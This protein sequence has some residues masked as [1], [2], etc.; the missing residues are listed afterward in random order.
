[1]NL[2]MVCKLMTKEHVQAHIEEIGIVP[3]ARVASAEEARFAAEAVARGGIPIIE[4]PM[5]VP[6]AVEV[7]S[8]LVRRLPEMIVGAGGVFDI[9][10]ARL[11]LGAGAKF[12]TTDALDPGIVEF[13]VQQQVVVFPGALTPTEVFTACKAGADF[14][15]VFPCAPLGGDSYI[16]ALKAPFPDA[17]LIA[18]GGVNQ[19]TAAK[20]ILAG[21][22]ALG[23]G[24]ELIPKDAVELRKEHQIRELVRRFVGFVREARAQM[25]PRREDV[26]SK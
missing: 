4:I 26:L 19:K 5:T 13:A 8:D 15:K 20:F 7:I 9:P 14:V 21:A 12:L 24:R 6:G 10:T 3:A 11:C 17:R 2:G 22:V 25:A 18:A 23:V 1:M 16:R